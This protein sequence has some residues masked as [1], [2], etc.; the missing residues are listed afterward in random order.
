MAEDLPLHHISIPPADE[1]E[2]P[3]AIVLVHGRG[4]HEQDL[5][6]LVEDFPDEFHILSVRA[7]T[8]LG[9]GYTW[10]E[11]DLAAGGLHKSQP[12]PD[13]F[14]RSLSLLTDFV[15]KAIPAYGLDAER[16][17]LIGFSQGAIMGLGAIVEY[18][19]VF[20]WVAALHGYLPS[21]YEATALA[22]AAG[23]P[24]FI[25]AGE[26][27]QIIPVERAE[28]AVERL[29]DAGVDVTFQTYPIGHGTSPQEVADLTAWF[30]TQVRSESV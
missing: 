3:P 7:P 15:E 29:R 24:V 22:A 14:D 1:T 9:P 2:N 13:G 6:P 8:P 16:I 17:G 30:Q 4:S 12:D 18:P 5:P 23:T 25:G 10:Y 28:K 21:R 19:S 11:L 20:R 27:D 26:T